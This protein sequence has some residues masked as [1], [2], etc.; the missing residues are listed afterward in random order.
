MKYHN[1]YVI[2][3]SEAMQKADFANNYDYVCCIT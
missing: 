3:C 1:Y 2:W